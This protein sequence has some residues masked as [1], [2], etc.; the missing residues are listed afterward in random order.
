MSKFPIIFGII[1]KKLYLLLL[2]AL[3][4]ILYNILR[5]EIILG[6]YAKSAINNPG[7]INNLQSITDLQVINNLG[8]NI[9]EMLSIFIPCIFKFKGKSKNST[10]KCTKANF[11]DYFILSLIIFLIIGIQTL[12]QRFNKYDIK[13]NFTYISL[14]FQMI[15]YILSS[16]II[17]KT[18]YYIHNIISSILFCIFSVII[19]LILDNFTIIEPISL[20]S[21]LP[22]LVDDLLCCYMK[23]LIDKRFHSYWNIL[24]FIGLFYFL[25]ILINFIIIIINDPYNN[26]IFKAIK[27]TEIKYIV[28]NFFLDAILK[29]FL[30]LLL[31]LII[32]EYFSLNHVLIS[33][34]LYRIVISIYLYESTIKLTHITDK[35][36]LLFLIPAFFQIIS[37]LFYLEIFEFNFCN[38]NR[39]TKRNIML[40]EEEEMLLRNKSIAS[41][42]EVEVDKD[43]IV[44]YPQEKNDLELYDIIDNSEEKENGSEN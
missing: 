11:K 43:L 17:L 23:Y 44:K 36:Y 12:L 21:L 16:I 2:L 9:L 15:F 28:L 4:L 19:D 24:F 26:Y 34:L 33:H 3:T 14:C 41:E 35:N 22:N 37:L 5:F 42:I 10:K 20:L 7:L 38:L 27:M 18:K 1:G 29:Q 25:F 6:F 8:G 31:T 13:M 40:R 32:L 39:N 30:R